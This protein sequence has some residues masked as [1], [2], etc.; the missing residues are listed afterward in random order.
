LLLGGRNLSDYLG[1]DPLGVAI[2]GFFLAMALASA[3]LTTRYFYRRHG[4]LAALGYV[5]AFW[6]LIGAGLALVA[7][8][9]PNWQSLVAL[10][11]CVLANAGYGV[12]LEVRRKDLRIQPEEKSTGPAPAMRRCPKCGLS[13][14]AKLPKC[15]MCG[16]EAQKR[17]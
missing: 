1:G 2:G 6:G 7:R 16:A 4:S 13:V 9:R 15:P 12:Y 17:S 8:G 11:V 3:V 10:G 14:D 5:V